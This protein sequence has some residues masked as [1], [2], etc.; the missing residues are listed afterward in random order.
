MT[1]K[2]LSNNSSTY[3]THLITIQ[4]RPE[5]VKFLSNNSST[6]PTHLITIQ[7]RPEKVITFTNT[8]CIHQHRKYPNTSKLFFTVVLTAVK[9]DETNYSE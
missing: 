8:H 2:F 7:G 4:G 9:M 6:Y 3:L 5:K 1:L